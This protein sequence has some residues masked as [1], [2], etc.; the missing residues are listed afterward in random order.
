VL[1]ITDDDGIHVPVESTVR[2]PR[3]T[4]DPTTAL[5]QRVVA[6]VFGPA[7]RRAFAVRYWSGVTEPGADV[8]DLPGPRFT[9]VLRHAAALRHMFL[10]PSELAVA[11][12]YI[13]G[14]IDLEGDMEAAVAVGRRMAG[15]LTSPSRLARITALLVR[16]PTRAV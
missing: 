5:A 12:A 14:D 4:D 9:L 1:R 2:R 10:P 6:E 8:A 15:Q 7:N 16:L 11:E 13:G 3:P